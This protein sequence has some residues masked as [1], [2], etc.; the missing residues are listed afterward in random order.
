[1]GWGVKSVG[2][3]APATPASSASPRGKAQFHVCICI[4]IISN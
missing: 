3:C 1:M 2:E 4:G